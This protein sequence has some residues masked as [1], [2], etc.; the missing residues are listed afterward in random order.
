M[1]LSIDR[2]DSGIVIVVV[3]GDVD[4]NTSHQVRNTLT[5]LFFEKPGALVV[6]L[7]DVNYIDSSGIA[8]LIEGLQRSLQYEIPFRLSGMNPAVKDVF[9]MAGLKSLFKIFDSREA[10]LK[11]LD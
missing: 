8:T 3:S 7:S 2:M 1:E 10:A 11:D 6:D 4:W 9:K 5:P